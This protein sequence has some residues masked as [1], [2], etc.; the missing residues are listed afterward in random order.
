MTPRPYQLLALAGIAEQFASVR[1]ALVVMPTGTGKT[2]LFAEAIQ[3][4]SHKRALVIAHR[5]ELIRQ[6]A[7]KIESVIGERPDIEMA[8]ERA[9][10]HMFRRSRVVVA[11]K[12]TLHPKRLLKFKPEDFD[13]IVTDEA[14]H[15]VGNSYRHIYDYF[16]DAKHLGVTATPDRTDERALGMVFDSVAFVYE[17]TDAINDGWLVPVSSQAVEVDGLDFSHVKST[18]GDLNQK[19]LAELM[20]AEKMLHEVAD[21]TIRIAKWRKTIVFAA[22]VKA[23]EHLA[24]IINRHRPNSAR[25]VC[26]ETP[27]E[28]RASVL[29]DYRAGRFQFLV[30]VGVF[31]E[32][33][34]EPSIEMVAIARPTESRALYAQMIGRGTRPLPGIVDGIDT[35]EER[36]EAI[37]SSRK[38]EL[39]IVDFEGNAGRHKLITTADVLGGNYDDEVV[40]RAQAKVKAAGGAVRVAAA[41]ADAEAELHREREIARR[42]RVT[43]TAN[44]TSRS[45]DP[46][47]VFDLEP[48]REREWDREKPLSEKQIEF[49]NKNGVETEGLSRGRASQLIGE[50][51]HRRKTGKCSYKQARLLRK[52]GLNPNVSFEEAKT[53]IDNLFKEKGWKDKK[54]ESVA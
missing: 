41:L 16:K 32:G 21:P 38:R 52:H 30:N 51:I 27:R 42:Q 39:L 35:A 13:L 17:V 54:Q 20:E 15:A 19:Q 37:A 2:I 26:G 50:I 34:D 7:D 28:T 18:A 36:R 44:Y 8:A 49:L 1:S 3:R 25:W 40:A 53:A 5:E 45:V 48:K 46:F 22:S 11:S 31:T 23:A 4:F 9:D 12:D 24:E 33:F 14:H 29:D 47:D 43:A 10:L 6:A